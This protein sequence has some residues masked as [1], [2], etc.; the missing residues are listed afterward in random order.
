[1]TVRS[2]PR[3]DT[4]RFLLCEDGDEYR[5]RFERFLGARFRFIQS[6]H[7]AELLSHLQDYQP[8]AGVLLDL[9]FRRTDDSLL[10]G[11]DGRPFSG[12]SRE[13]RA[14][15]VANQGIAI[16]ASIREK[17]WQ[18][19]VLLFADIHDTRQRTYL[20]RAFAPVELIP[21]HVGL[22]ELQRR[23]DDLSIIS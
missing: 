22:N 15:I 18:T 21:S 4:P 5:E 2:D 3:A 1:M 14:R 7:G 11:G 17:H 20:E 8:I 9:D 16:L 19:P 6:K 13:E 23:L 10:V 12:T